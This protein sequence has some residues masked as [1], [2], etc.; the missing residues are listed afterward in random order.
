MSELRTQY[1]GTLGFSENETTK[2]KAAL[3]R[4]YELR[5]FEI[6]H[7]WKRATY[8][9]AFQVAIFAALGF[10]WGKAD[11]ND[12][13]PVTAAL[14]G[15]GILT[16]VANALSARGSRF[17]QE[18]W[19]KHIDMLEND[20][21]GRLYKTVW[22]RDR[23]VS[24]SVSRINQYL[25]YYFIVFWVI[26]ALYVAC[27]L[28]GW[29][30]RISFASIYVPILALMIVVGVVFL[31]GQTTNLD[32]G[33]LPKPDGSYGA[34]INRDCCKPRWRWPRWCKHIL[35]AQSQPFIRRRAPDEQR[36]QQ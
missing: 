6:E 33:T 4:A 3:K 9:W 15:L 26:V 14:A 35:G 19:E 5:N 12:W 16:A 36:A 34:P 2:L 18:N 25:S 21:E 32:D 13:S 27:R 20:I 24:F 30:L 17:W 22:M 29:P 11:T 8:F 31:Y 28:V 10:L 23:K 1:F 7:Y